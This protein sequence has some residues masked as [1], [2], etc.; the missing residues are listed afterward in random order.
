MTYGTTGT[1]FI[2]RLIGCLSKFMRMCTRIYARV[3][4]IEKSVPLVPVVPL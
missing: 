4:I 3:G 1:R 2:K